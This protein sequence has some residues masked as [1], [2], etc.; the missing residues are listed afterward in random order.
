M[1]IKGL[2]GVSE[3]QFIEVEFRGEFATHLVTMMDYMRDGSWAQIRG[4]W[5]TLYCRQ[6]LPSYLISYNPRE[7]LDKGD[8]AGAYPVC[9][10]YALGEYF[11]RRKYRIPYCVEDFMPPDPNRK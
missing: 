9:T 2:N 10:L 6:G 7:M 11:I 4:C 8:L 5:Y 3:A 1:Q